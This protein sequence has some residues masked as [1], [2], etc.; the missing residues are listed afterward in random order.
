MS[1]VG[2]ITAFAAEASLWLAGAAIIAGA[3]GAHWDTPSVDVNSLIAQAWPGASPSLV[4]SYTSKVTA[5][6]FQAS[7]SI[8]G[9]VS[10][11]ISGQKTD[12]TYS[13]AFK[14]KGNDS[15]QSMTL[16]MAATSATPASSSVSD[17][18]DSGGFT[19]SRTDGGAWTKAAKTSDTSI[20]SI[21]AQVGLADQGVESHFNQ[22]LHRLESTKTVPPSVMFSDMTGITN[23]VV[24]LTF[25][26]KDDGSPAGMTMAATYTQATSGT[27][28]DVSLRMDVSFDSLSGVT[29]EVPSV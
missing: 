8:A 28:G 14:I 15:A 12:G 17:S 19:Y 2:G 29:I 24:A 16:D 13:G 9:T 25:W 10:V 20:Q 1:K 4:P 5:S 23:A 11:T 26:A 21:I 27:S 6:D 18:V 22:Q 3:A 7:G